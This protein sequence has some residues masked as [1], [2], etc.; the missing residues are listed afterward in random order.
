MKLGKAHIIFLASALLSITLEFSF[1]N[2]NSWF[3]YDGVIKAVIYLSLI[4][5]LC[6]YGVFQSIQFKPFKTDFKSLA[7]AIAVFI[8][9]GAILYL[10]NIPKNRNEVIIRSYYDGGSNGI[11]LTLYSNSEFIMKDFSLLG[12]DY[13][14]GNYK[15][16]DEHLTLIYE[17]K[18]ERIKII[19]TEFLINNQKIEPINST[20][21]YTLKI[22]KN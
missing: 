17:E 10:F 9:T 4:L 19:G 22:L 7:F 13:Y 15:I 1:E 21:S 8:A 20:S 14:K 3:V 18:F 11:S 6:I 5:P 2:K 12:G 16:K